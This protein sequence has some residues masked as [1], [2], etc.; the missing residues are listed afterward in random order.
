MEPNSY[1]HKIF[2]KVHQTSNGHEKVVTASSRD[3][4]THKAKHNLGTKKT[5]KN[6]TLEKHNHES[7]LGCRK[8]GGLSW[9]RKDG[10]SGSSQRG[11]AFG[12][13]GK[14]PFLS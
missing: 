12:S 14:R 8:R 5:P 7:G 2:Y 3:T 6:L 11:G 1:L 4:H 13:T 9:T 10:P